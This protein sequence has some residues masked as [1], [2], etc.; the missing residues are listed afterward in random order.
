M[1]LAV[2]TPAPGSRIDQ[3]LTL[4]VLAMLIVG[5]FVVLQPFL[6]AL[7]WAGW[8]YIT[9]GA[10]L[11]D[12]PGQRGGNRRGDDQKAG[13]ESSEGSAHG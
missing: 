1:P 12:L 6:T 4:A 8:P 3:A 11:L 7:V 10:V 5:C 9:A 2:T 13:G